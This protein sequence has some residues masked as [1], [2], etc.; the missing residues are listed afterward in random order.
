MR[1]V[2]HS[3]DLTADGEVELDLGALGKVDP[4][5]HLEIRDFVFEF[6]VPLTNPNLDGAPVGTM[7]DRNPLSSNANATLVSG[8]VIVT[9]DETNLEG[10]PEIAG[11]LSDAYAPQLRDE[12]MDQIVEQIRR[13]MSIN[14]AFACDRAGGYR[15]LTRTRN[16]KGRVIS[17]PP[18]IST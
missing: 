6:L 18:F 13:Q 2:I 7:A 5:L 12:M 1:F 14:A 11:I 10:F 4:N 3:P 9:V 15:A 17:H 8:G 16:E